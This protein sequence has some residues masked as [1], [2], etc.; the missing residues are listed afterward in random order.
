MI[1]HRLLLIELQNLF[2]FHLLFY[3]YLF[4]VSGYHIVFM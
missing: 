4:T 2:G 3:Y 1:I